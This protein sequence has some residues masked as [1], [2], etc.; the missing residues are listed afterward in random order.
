M[1]VV[2][3]PREVLRYPRLD[4]VLM[5]EKAVY[6]HR[7]AATVTQIWKSLPKKAMWQTFSLVLEY[8]EHEGKIRIEDD[9]T[10]TWIWDPE[11]VKKIL[12]SPRLV[13]R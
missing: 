12:S 3:K 7:S 6:E 5:I 4:T 11:G 2:F 8:L 10:V 13:V 9:K 1:E